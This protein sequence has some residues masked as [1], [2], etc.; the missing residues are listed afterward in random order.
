MTDKVFR[1]VTDLL[2]HGNCEPLKAAVHGVVLTL[3]AVCAAYNTAAWLK[4]RQRHLAINAVF[5]AT[6][7]WLERCHVQHHLAAC[8]E[9]GTT[10][11]LRKAA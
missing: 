5:Y 9:R 11:R 1:P 10:P 4:R 6:A 2:D 8:E 3:A 7:V